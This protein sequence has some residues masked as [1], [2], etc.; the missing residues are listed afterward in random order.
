MHAYTVHA[1]SSGCALC[2]SSRHH[3]RCQL[4]IPHVTQA[5]STTTNIQPQPTSIW[6]AMVAPG[7]SPSLSLRPPQD[8]EPCAWR[9]SGAIR[10]DIAPGTGEGSMERPNLTLPLTLSFMSPAAFSGLRASPGRQKEQGHGRI[11]MLIYSSGL[12]GFTLHRHL[13]VCCF[14]AWLVSSAQLQES[15]SQPPLVTLDTIPHAKSMHATMHKSSDL[16]TPLHQSKDQIAPTCKG[17]APHG[18]VANDT[19]LPASPK[20]HQERDNRPGHDN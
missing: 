17:V 5:K 14:L 2:W 12:C 7:S 6:A 15:S 18:L 19:P 20:I 16:M 11:H 1:A 3:S 8:T 4:P 10:L 9:G 13:S